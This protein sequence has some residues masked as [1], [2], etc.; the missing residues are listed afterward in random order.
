MKPGDRG[1]GSVKKGTYLLYE[2]GAVKNRLQACIESRRR[3]L[4]SPIKRCSRSKVLILH[5]NNPLH[6]EW[7][8]V[9]AAS[10]LSGMNI[11]K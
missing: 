2:F 1:F 6:F 7:F 3:R 5:Y 10:V 9:M 8:T 11:A 4:D